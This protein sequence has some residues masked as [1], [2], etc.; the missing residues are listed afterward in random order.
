MSLRAIMKYRGW[1]AWQTHDM[2]VSLLALFYLLFVDTVSDSLTAAILV[3]VFGFYFMCGFLIND[4]FDRPMDIKA[5]KIRAVQELP[6][7]IV[8]GIILTLILVI[9]ILL[10]YLNSLFFTALYGFSFFLGTLYSAPPVR[11]KERGFVGIIINALT[12]KMLPVLAIFV[13]FNHFGIDTLIFVITTFLLQTIEIMTHQLYD[14]EADLKT[15]TRT[16]AIDIGKERALHMFSSIVVPLSLVFMLLL[17]SLI[18]L[19]IPYAGLIIIAVGVLYLVITVLVNTGRLQM[20]EKI[21]PLYMSPLYLLIN[22]A[23]PLLLALL[24]MDASFQNIFLL[25]VAFASQY[26]LFKQLFI[27]IRDGIIPRTEIAD[28]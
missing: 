15:R 16:F 22:N 17:C 10:W 18:A 24:L 27:M 23:F 4:F 1:K 8:F 19:K 7:G 13:F 26:Y 25:A 6:R 12:E 21:L 11:F 20:E 2:H 14:Y 5:G 28:T 3:L 9:L